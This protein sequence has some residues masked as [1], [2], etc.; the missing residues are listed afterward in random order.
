MVWYFMTNSPDVAPEAPPSRAPQVILHPVLS[1]PGWVASSYF[2][3]NL[4]KNIWMPLKKLSKVSSSNVHQLHLA[5]QLSSFHLHAPSFPPLGS[6]W[7][8]AKSNLLEHR[9]LGDNFNVRVDM[10]NTQRLMLAWP[11]LHATLGMP[12]GFPLALWGSQWSREN[13]R[14][15]RRRDEMPFDPDVN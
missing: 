5:P 11:L 4:A 9:Y 1:E 10:M 14:K 7:S 3:S 6:G 2:R 8:E 12:T 13:N 15:R